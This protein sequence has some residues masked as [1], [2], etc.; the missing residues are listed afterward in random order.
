VPV[1]IGRTAGAMSIGGAMFAVPIG[2]QSLCTVAP[3][4]SI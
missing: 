2:I 4:K 3:A 1:N